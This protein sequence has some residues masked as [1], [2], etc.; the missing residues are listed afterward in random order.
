MNFFRKR[1]DTYIQREHVKIFGSKS[2]LSDHAT[3][4]IV[5]T[6]YLGEILKLS[7]E[8]NKRKKQW[9]IL[10]ILKLS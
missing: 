9:R 5:K 6:H 1:K 7:V 8:K 3:F 2:S 10:K 4:H